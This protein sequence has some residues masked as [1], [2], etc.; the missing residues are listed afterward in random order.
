MDELIAYCPHKG[1]G[2]DEDNATLLSILQEMTKDTSYVSS[3]TPHVRRR[4]GRAAYLALSQHNMGNV[5]FQKLVDD[6]EELVT[7]RI[8]DGRNTRYILETHIARHRDAYNDMVQASQYITYNLPDNR[9]RVNRLLNSIT[10][11]DTAVVSAKTQILASSQFEHNFEA[12]AEFLMKCCG[13]K[14]N[15]KGHNSH[16][17]SAVRNG[18]KQKRDN[19]CDKGSTGVALRYHTKQEYFKLKP[20]QKKELK[21]WRASQ[22]E[23]KKQNI[24]AVQVLQSQ[25]KAL[26]TKLEELSRPVADAIQSIKATNSILKNP[27]KPPPRFNQRKDNGEERKGSNQ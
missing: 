4:N 8:W 17:I 21:E 2:F 9:T 23:A 14:A 7:R 15:P 3:I 18:G 12:A 11:N 25:V 10:S 16:R 13:K 22:H 20:E 1:P 26:T 24:A 19:N 6:A 27:L 5:R